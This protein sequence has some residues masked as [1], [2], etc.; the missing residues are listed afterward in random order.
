MVLRPQKFSPHPR[1][2][3]ATPMLARCAAAWLLALSALSTPHGQAQQKP[4]AATENSQPTFEVAAIKPSKPGDGNHNWDDSPG[5]VSIENYT[6]RRLISVAYGL[7]SESQV[8]G[9]PKWV[10]TECFDTV[11]K[12]DDAETEAMQ[13]M[14]R[15]Q[16]VQARSQML[17]AFLADRFQLKVS[18]GE[19]RMSV[20]ALVVSKSG[21][22]F[23]PS[24]EKNSRGSDFSGWNGRL[25]ATNISMDEFAHDLAN[26]DEVGGRLVINRTGLPATF[27]LKMNFTRDHGDG[28]PA[29]AVYPGLFT[30]LKEQ[31]GL[32]L[33][34]EK[35][36]VPVI[37]VDSA[38][39]PVFD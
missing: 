19:R 18:S 6:L 26:F 14:N 34:P 28:I 15:Q 7:K 35:A 20:F 21:A 38:S 3:R 36:P 32:E 8:L 29:D 23:M 31:L 1:N 30:A 39:E 9:G 4:A 17:Q 37:V 33:K 2:R 13:K 24:P 10:R 5:R 25:T 22:K 27:D 12:A 11:A 16:W